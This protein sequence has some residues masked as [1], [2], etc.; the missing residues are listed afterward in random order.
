MSLHMTKVAYGCASLDELTTRVAGR[1]ASEG[2]MFMT[3][4]YIPK[5]HDEIAGQG[6]LFWIIKHQLIARAAILGFEQNAEGRWDI[7]LEPR[8]IPVRPLP[9]RAHQGWRYL[10]A[11]D[12]PAD[13][14]DG[15]ATGDAMPPA[16]IGELADL[17]LI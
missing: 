10:A 7:M 13:L 14:Q 5:R 1:I 2:R 17:S 4:R 3:T 8:V 12:A 11:A 16:L 9:R 6:S 15:E